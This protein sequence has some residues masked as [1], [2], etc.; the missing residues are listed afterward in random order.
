MIE[1]FNQKTLMGLLR[2]V[3]DARDHYRQVPHRKFIINLLRN[4]KSLHTLDIEHALE[5]E[6][7]RHLARPL[8]GLLMRMTR[9]GVLIQECDDKGIRYRLSKPLLDKKLHLLIED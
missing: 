4:G 8:E 6:W 2:E 1:G 7:N 9:E 5:R 3:R